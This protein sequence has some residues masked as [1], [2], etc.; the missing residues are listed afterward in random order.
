MSNQSYN[1][2]TRLFPKS[3]DIPFNFGPFGFLVF[4]TK[5]VHI[6]SL[7]LEVLNIHIYIY[8]LKSYLKHVNHHL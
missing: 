1:S 3:E 2:W 7:E 8:I 4:I 6:I 5:N